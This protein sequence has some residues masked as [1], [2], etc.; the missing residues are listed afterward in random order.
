[1]PSW[2]IPVFWPVSHLYALI[3]D[4]KPK[5]Q[6]AV[7]TLDIYGHLTTI[8]VSFRSWLLAVVC[9]YYFYD[10]YNYPGYGRGKSLSL[11]WV[12]PIMYRNLIGTWL[13]C[14][15]WD[16]ILYFSPLKYKFEKYKFTKEYP[17]FRQFKH[18]A[19]VTTIA[20]IIAGLVEVLL[21]YLWSNNY[22]SYTK[23]IMDAPVTNILLAMNITYAR[24]PHFHLIHRM[25]HPWKTNIIPDF[26][27]ILYKYVHYLHHRSYNPIAFSGTS[28][29]PVESLLYYSAVIVLLPFGG[30]PSIAI[31]VMFIYTSVCIYRNIAI[32]ITLHLTI[33]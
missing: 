28:M 26:G 21:C 15:F 8:S 23:N 2:F 1:M 7:P 10:N 24:V 3:T 30:H 27:K 31:G 9:M 11:D 29:H 14:G 25:I 17:S 13:I 20:S 19:F 32:Y 22:L 5:P 12:L 4:T 18:D 33:Y 6:K 16:W